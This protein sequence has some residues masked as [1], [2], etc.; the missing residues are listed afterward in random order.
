[1]SKIVR[2]ENAADILYEVEV[3]PAF[4]GLWIAE[5]W[6]NCGYPGRHSTYKTLLCRTPEAALSKAEKWIEKRHR[7]DGAKESQA[8]RGGKYYYGPAAMREP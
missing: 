3:S 7:N 8:K 5:I 6:P 1:M 2:R 4:W